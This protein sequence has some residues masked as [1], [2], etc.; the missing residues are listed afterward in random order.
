MIHIGNYHLH[1]KI[2]HR[3]KKQQDKTG[4]H[5]KNMKEWNSSTCHSSW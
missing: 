1:R 3:K 2:S 4:T 5:R